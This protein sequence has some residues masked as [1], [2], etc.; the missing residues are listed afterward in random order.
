MLS[1]S[2]LLFRCTNLVEELPK[3]VTK[4]RLG[5]KG[6]VFTRHGGFPPRACLPQAGDFSGTT[7]YFN[8]VARDFISTSSRFNKSFPLPRS[9]FKLLTTIKEG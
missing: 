9:Y 8:P 7:S 2:F 3:A 4:S 1:F 5:G 6:V